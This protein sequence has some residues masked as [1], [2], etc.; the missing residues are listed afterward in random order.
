MTT[1][2]SDGST[3][4]IAVDV[5]GAGIGQVPASWDFEADGLCCTN[6]VDSAL[7]L[8]TPL[9]ADRIGLRPPKFQ[10][11]IEQLAGKR[12]LPLLGLIALRPQAVAERPFESGKGILGMGLIIIA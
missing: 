7:P 8:G 4:N 12:S 3:D 1:G 9:L 10:H 6:R 11:P 2:A 5:L